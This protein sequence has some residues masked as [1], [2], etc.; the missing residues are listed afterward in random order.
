MV[1]AIEGISSPISSAVVPLTR[2]TIKRLQRCCKLRIRLTTEKL[3]QTHQAGSSSLSSN[4]ETP[5]YYSRLHCCLK[6]EQFGY[7]IPVTGTDNY[8]ADIAE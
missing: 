8:S 6:Y 7:S 5:K 1:S 2:L 3:V 4:M